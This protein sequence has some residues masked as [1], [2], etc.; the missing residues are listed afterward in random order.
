[1]DTKNIDSQFAK[2][3]I[4][5]CVAYFV[6]TGIVAFFGQSM[7]PEDSAV[8]S[9]SLIYG[10]LVG[11]AIVQ[12]L[13]LFVGNRERNL[14]ILSFTDTCVATFIIKSTGASSSP[15]QVLLPLL[16]LVAS[17]QFTNSIY[18]ISSLVII[19]A[20]V[21]LAIGFQAA[22]AGTAVAAIATAIVG[23]YLRQALEKTGKALTQTEAQRNRLENLQR[24]IMANI[25]SGLLSVDSRGKMI[26]VNRFALNILGLSEDDIIGKALSD[27]L[28]ELDQLRAQLETRTSISDLYEPIANRKSI[29]FKSRNGKEIRLGYSLARLSS[30]E[31]REIL[32]TLIL[33]QDLTEAISK[34]ESFQLSEKL[35]AVGKLAA[36][37]AHEIR[38][39]LAGISGAAQLLEAESLT[40][41]NQRLLAI[42]KRESSRL[43]AL[44]SEFLE[45]VRPAAPKKEPFAL[46]KVTGQVVESLSVNPKWKSYNCNLHFTAEPSEIAAQGDENKV[47]QVLL[48]LLLN[49]GQAGAKDVWI[50]VT[51]GLN[52]QIL[53]NGP[54]IPQN[55]Q[56]QVFEPFFTTKDKGTG[57]GLAIA[58]KTLQG[59][60]ASIALKSPV[61]D[62]EKGGTLFEIHFEKAGSNSK[63]AA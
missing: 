37:I 38:N 7:I 47:S 4:T 63:E 29:P 15:F 13:F 18:R 34:E 46:H 32:G 48:N 39:P 59:V 28:P 25:P 27:I 33:F 11:L 8:V 24:V 53:D 20:V 61:P 30:P 19:L 36:G 44:I 52:V 58:Y 57:L 41:D 56:A 43:D 23:F 40:E 5:R 31:N 55:M 26:Q 2:L 50:E 10:V 42:I 1:V 51:E 17:V 62:F 49:A 6:I 45:Y 54:G 35:A 3:L 21:P 9:L 14:F 22:V 16:S 12:F 60:G